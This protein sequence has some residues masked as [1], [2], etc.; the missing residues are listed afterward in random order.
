MRT[1]IWHHMIAA[2]YKAIYL[3]Y[4]NSYIR[5]L[6]RW[7]EGLLVLASSGAIAG[8]LI[9]QHLPWLWA[10]I[11]GAAQLVK[12]LKPYLPFLKERD[13]LAASYVFYQQQHFHYECLWEDIESEKYGDEELR[14]R[15]LDI[16]SRQLE[17]DERTSHFLVPEYNF[18]VRKTERQWKEYLKTNHQIERNH[19]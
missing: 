10:A 19:E 12:V 16:K 2:R 18:L 7:L 3:S 6:D 14:Q 11:I 13:Q 9:W 15:Y 8:W 4:F 1:K 17:E 5:S